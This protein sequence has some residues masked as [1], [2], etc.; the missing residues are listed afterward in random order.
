MEKRRLLLVFCLVLISL[1][2]GISGCPNSMSPTNAQFTI[3]VS[4]T[5]GA[6]FTGF[7]THEVDYTSGSR[8]EETEIKGTITAEKT[9]LEFTIPG[10]E[11]SCKITN[12]TPEKPITI[13][14]YK[15]GSEVKRL[16]GIEFDGYL[17]WYPPIVIDTKAMAAQGFRYE[18]SEH[19]GTVYEI[20]EFTEA[21]KTK[22]EDLIEQLPQEVKQQF[23][24]EF[25]SFEAVLHDPIY[26]VISSPYWTTTEPYQQLL[27]YCREQGE[28]VWP[29]IFQRLDQAD[30]FESYCI[31]SLLVDMTQDEYGYILEAIRQESQ[32]ERYTEDSMYISPSGG[33]NLMKYAKE[34]L[35][36]L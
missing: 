12:K 8:T 17:S 14:L 9:A 31:G 15:D 3:R 25:A 29:L 21:E 22:I 34:L 4:G 16:D 7:C 19:T 6:E 26:S 2:A 28:G 35:A 23:E 30:T 36:L 11:I 33:A 24:G 32:H 20:V 18:P 5:P 27:Q 1:L 10:T 13:V